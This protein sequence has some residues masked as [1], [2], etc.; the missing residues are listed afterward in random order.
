MP[1]LHS[2]TNIGNQALPH[3]KLSNYCISTLLLCLIYVVAITLIKLDGVGI[4]SDQNNP[5]TQH[6]RPYITKT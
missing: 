3:A 4:T 1:T 2:I 5:P 6:P